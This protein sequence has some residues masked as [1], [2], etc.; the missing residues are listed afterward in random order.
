M[1]LKFL[2]KMIS[3]VRLGFATN[4]SSSH[5]LVVYNEDLTDEKFDDT[6]N[7]WSF[8]W[9]KFILSSKIL[10]MAYGILATHSRW[11]VLE[12]DTEENY[13]L[14][15]QERYQPLLEEMNFSP[16]QIE[17]IFNEVN[18]FVEVDHQSKA[19][20]SEGSQEEKEYFEL[21]SNSRLVIYGG[22]DNGGPGPWDFADMGIE[23]GIEKV[24]YANDPFSPDMIKESSDTSYF[25][26]LEDIQ[27][28]VDEL[29]EAFIAAVQ[30]EQV[31]PHNEP[32]NYL[33]DVADKEDF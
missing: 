10:K 24:Y 8:G 1:L 23:Y 26:S 28:Q 5:S 7:V 2:S 15:L 20:I 16:D 6:S 13:D 21:L 30:N 31:L 27:T 19:N 29:Q 9:D 22:N 32:M 14:Y 33:E 3:N 18:N 25:I 17:E 11:A 12:E 4:S